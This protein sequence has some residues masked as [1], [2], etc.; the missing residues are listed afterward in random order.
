VILYFDQ[1][2]NMTLA[3]VSCE[4]DMR[5]TTSVLQ[6]LP[7]QSLGIHWSAFAWWSV[8]QSIDKLCVCSYL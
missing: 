2:T 6:V 5:K 3:S 1:L 4:Q 8:P 7:S